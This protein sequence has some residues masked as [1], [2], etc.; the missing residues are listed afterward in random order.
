M[1]ICGE[2]CYY[3]PYNKITANRNMPIGF[4]YKNN[5]SYVGPF[6]TIKAVEIAKLVKGIT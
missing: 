2:N 1:I 6:A 5:K 4:Y 3:M